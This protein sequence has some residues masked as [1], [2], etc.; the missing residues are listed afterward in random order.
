MADIGIRIGMILR[1]GI[2]IWYQNRYE[3]C[4]LVSGIGIGMNLRYRYRYW[5]GYLAGYWYRY[6]YQGIGGTLNL[7]YIYG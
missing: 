6:R 3:F 5:Y 2:G 1:L 7:W 4:V